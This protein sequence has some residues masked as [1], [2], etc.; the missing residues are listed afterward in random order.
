DVP[1]REA[2]E[3]LRSN[4][5]LKSTPVIILTANSEDEADAAS[6][7]TGVLLRKPVSPVT[8]RR[9]IRGVLEKVP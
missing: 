6:L 8:I 2:V 7:P 4:P 3:W 1:G 9:A 5:A